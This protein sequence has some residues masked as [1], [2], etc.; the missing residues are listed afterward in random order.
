MPGTTLPVT[1]GPPARTGPASAAVRTS[2]PTT[3]IERFITGSPSLAVSLAV[4]RL[5]RLAVA[6]E[7]LQRGLT[8]QDRVGLPDRIGDA[9]LA[10]GID[11]LAHALGGLR[12][13][14]DH[15]GR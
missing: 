3:E 15:D 4:V 6:E 1:G 9:L 13:L 10:V 7:P 12:D 11:P 5:R 8:G 2:A 14:E